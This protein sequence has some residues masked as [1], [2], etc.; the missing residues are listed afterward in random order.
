MV[1]WS[2]SWFLVPGDQ[3]LKEEMTR[4]ANAGQYYISLCLAGFIIFL[5]LD[6]K[7]S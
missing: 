6:F 2:P 3:L 4:T 5:N 7:L 1:N